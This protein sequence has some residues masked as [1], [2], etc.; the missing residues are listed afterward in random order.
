MIEDGLPQRIQMWLCEWDM[1]LHEGEQFR[2]RLETLGKDVQS[3]VIP[4]VPHGWDKSPNPFRNQKAIDELY[5][6][7]AGYLRNVFGE[8]AR[9]ATVGE[10]I[11]FGGMR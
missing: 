1:L 9:R 5:M 11:G 10:G 4:G 7:S 8:A 6:R 3:E 2:D